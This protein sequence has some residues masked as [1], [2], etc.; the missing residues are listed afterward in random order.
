MN[1]VRGYS[2]PTHGFVLDP[3][4][5]QVS[6]FSFLSICRCQVGLSYE[7][8][9]STCQDSDTLSLRGV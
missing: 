3:T 6:V 5:G 8:V 7:M 1:R 2:M 9:I 4:V